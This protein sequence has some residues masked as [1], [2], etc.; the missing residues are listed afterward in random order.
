MDNT[1]IQYSRMVGNPSE[2][3]AVCTGMQSLRK[4]LLP[5]GSSEI[6]DS[7]SRKKYNKNL[8]QNPAMCSNCKMKQM[9]L[10]SCSSRKLM[11]LLQSSNEK[12]IL[13]LLDSELA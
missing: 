11:K 5:K 3:A 7:P 6:R 4:G 1:I 2:E 12:V 10:S 13:F 9:C 8:K